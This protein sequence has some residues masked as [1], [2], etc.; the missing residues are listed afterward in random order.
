MKARPIIMDAESVRGILG[1]RKTQTRRVCRPPAPYVPTDEGLDILFATEQLP[2]PYGQ[3]GDQL[4]VKE[5]WG[6]HYGPVYRATDSGQCCPSSGWKP[7]IFMPRRYSR[8]TLRI[9]S[10]R[11][12]RLQS[13]SLHDVIAEGWP[14][15][16]EMFPMVNTTDKAVAW[17]EYRWNTINAKRGLPWE[18][19]PWVWVIEFENT[20][21]NGK[22][23]GDGQHNRS[24]SM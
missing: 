18:S 15:D 20:G 13:I 3:P 10:I 5:T 17:F 23:K 24:A 4:W 7:S 9:L 21:G 8:I 2:C 22:D 14:R 11:I 12:E 16:R 1:G 6:L 19:N